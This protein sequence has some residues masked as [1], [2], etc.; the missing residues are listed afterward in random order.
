M[1]TAKQGLE[2]ILEPFMARVK[3]RAGNGLSRSMNQ[4]LRSYPIIPQVIRQSA[5]WLVRAEQT[6]QFSGVYVRTMHL[7]WDLVNEHDQFGVD[8]PVITKLQPLEVIE[9]ISQLPEEEM[10]IDPA[11]HHAFSGTV[12]FKRKAT[13]PY[14]QFLAAMTIARRIGLLGGHGRLGLTPQVRN[15]V[16]QALTES[17]VRGASDADQVAS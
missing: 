15:A 9:T 7:Y 3:V 14:N 8:V 17:S 11:D 2:T 4:T 6:F 1:G 12:D 16:S 13:L 10:A 5:L